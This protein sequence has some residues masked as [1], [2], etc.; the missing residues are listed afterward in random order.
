[1]IV[2]DR[3]INIYNMQASIGSVSTV[4]KTWVLP[5]SQCFVG[6]CPLGTFCAFLLCVLIIILFSSI[7]FLT[8]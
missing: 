2:A 3:K 5:S 8:V 1:M 6:L 7:I 4:D